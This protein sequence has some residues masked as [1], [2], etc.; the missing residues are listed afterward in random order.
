MQYELKPI[1]AITT[2]RAVVEVLRLHGRRQ[3]PHAVAQAAVWHLA[4]G[5]SWQQLATKER[6]NLSVPNTPYF[7]RST[8]QWAGQLVAYAQQHAQSEAATAYSPR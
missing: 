5:V 7:S 4:N 6:K 8:L 2:D 1:S 3:I